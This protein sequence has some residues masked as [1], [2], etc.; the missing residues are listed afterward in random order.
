LGGL[1]RRASYVKSVRVRESNLLLL[2]AGG[3]FGGHDEGARRRAEV[4]IEGMSLMGYD[5]LNL[6]D[7]EFL[8]SLPGDIP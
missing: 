6:G 3:V 1:A 5:A 7:E 8:L 2:D 4:L